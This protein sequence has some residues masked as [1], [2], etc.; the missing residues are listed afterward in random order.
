M[1]MG[2]VPVKTQVAVVG[3]GVGGYSAAFH[4]A[5]LGLEVTLVSE[6]PRLGG[7]CLLR[8]CIPSKTLL[9][10]CD[11]LH[12]A[13]EARSKG[14]RFGD[15]EIDLEKI[16]DWKDQ[17]VERLAKGLD[18]LAQD[19][20]V[21]IIRG[22]ARFAGPNRL[23][24]HGDEE[25]NVSF[26]HAVLAIGS[27]PTALPFAE[28]GGS[29]WS[30]VEA[31]RMKE[32]P[33]SFLIVGGGYVG[34]EMGSVYASLGAKV[35]LVEQEDRLLPEAD[36]DLVEPL[37]RRVEDLFHAVHLNCSVSEMEE[38]DDGVSV[39]FEGDDAPEDGSFRK[40][41]VAVGRSPSTSD[42][43]LEDAGVELDEDGFVMVDQELRTSTKA[44]LAVGDVVGGARLAHK[45][46]REGKV[47]AEVLAGQPSAY[48]PRAV[49]AVVYTDPEIAWCGLSEQGCESRR[50]GDHRRPLSL[51]SLRKSGEH[52]GRGRVHEADSGSRHPEGAGHGHLWAPGRGSHRR[53]SPCHGDGGRGPGPGP[54]HSSP[55]H[56]IRDNPGGCRSGP[57]QGNPHLIRVRHAE[58]TNVREGDP[59]FERRRGSDPEPD[60]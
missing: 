15:P 28:I 1:V 55:S 11:L 27:R 40:V 5:D 41:L 20:S 21:E 18:R 60:C 59:D 31:L 50:T 26:E 24:V 17:V 34:L 56:A 30:S 46:M 32:I 14:I 37:A 12:S 45:A 8:G 35:T 44:I 51:A 23:H 38:T 6:E 22:R 2:D 43:G 47:A 49:P 3:G 13:R 57:G 54:H 7:E 25:V 33:E 16:R 9:S 29:I 39:S 19:R 52:G 48:D 10:L 4:A 42:L 58:V 36:A 53:G